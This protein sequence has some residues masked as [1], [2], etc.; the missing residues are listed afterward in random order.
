MTYYVCDGSMK[1]Q[2]VGAG[3]VRVDGKKV[4]TMSFYGKMKKKNEINCEEYAVIKTLE[5][6]TQR[7]ETAITIYNDNLSE[8]P[9][10][11][12][13][14][15]A[16]FKKQGIKISILHPKSLK[17]PSYYEMAH[18]LS[19]IYLTT[20]NKIKDLKVVFQPSQF[21]ES[22][23]NV[24]TLLGSLKSTKSKAKKFRG[25]KYVKNDEVFKFNKMM[26]K[27]Y[28]SKES[29]MTDV[30]LASDNDFLHSKS[31]IFQRIGNRYW[32][33]FNEKQKLLIVDRE[34]KSISNLFLAKMEALKLS[35]IKLNSHY[36]SCL[37]G[38]S[39]GRTAEPEELDA[40]FARL[41]L[42]KV[43][44]IEDFIFIPNKRL[45]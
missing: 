3:V 32:G 24:T 35:H 18:N 37:E 26:M 38:L 40:L 11:K 4:R 17:N 21:N 9:P 22:P 10:R 12:K 31:Y 2:I 43:I 5:L 1:N 30:P 42:L 27:E 8:N 34:L 36:I 45:P 44:L 41:K 25:F 19:R 16:F 15:I 39:N 33:V 13:K 20:K 7:N 23:H 29:L 6:A 28:Y 14:I